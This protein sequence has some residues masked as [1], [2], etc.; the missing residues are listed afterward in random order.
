MFTKIL[1]TS[2]P[3]KFVIMKHEN[4]KDVILKFVDLIND[5]STS[6]IDID[7]K[8]NVDSYIAPYDMMYGV[9]STFHD[10]IEDIADFT[11]TYYNF[12][13]KKNT[14]VFETIWDIQPKIKDELSDIKDFLNKN[15]LTPQDAM[16][17]LNWYFRK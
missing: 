13:T 17:A 12:D 11:T 5:V 4:A 7:F 10:I 6:L 3:K 16:D 15:N 8:F 9:K 2:I 1:H 14:I